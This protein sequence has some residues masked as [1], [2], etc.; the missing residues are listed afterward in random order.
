MLGASTC[1]HTTNPI[2][3]FVGILTADM[4]NFSS[5]VCG[6][7]EASDSNAV[8]LLGFLYKCY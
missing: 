3:D 4:H 6:T 8:L 7:G 5:K 1:T 2:I